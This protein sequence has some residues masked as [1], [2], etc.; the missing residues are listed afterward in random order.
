MEQEF[1]DRINL[2]TDLSNIS[3]Q[4][5][6]KYKLGNYISDSVITV[7]YE[8]FNYVLETSTGKYC[9][10]VFNRERTD[11]DCKNYIDRIELASSLEVNTPKLYKVDGKGEHDIILEN[12]KYRLCVFDYIE[13]ESFF[14]LGIIPNENEIKE[15][16]RQ[17][18]IIHKVC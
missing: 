15:I 17:M 12:V 2:N 7:G 18:A 8:D 3:K 10:K 4:I 5:C 13:G 11:E 16:I 9:V 6:I 14:D 1:K